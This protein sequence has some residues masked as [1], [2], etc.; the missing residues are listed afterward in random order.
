M[1]TVP[2]SLYIYANKQEIGQ[3]VV[4][5]LLDG[6]STRWSLMHGVGDSMGPSFVSGPDASSIL[7]GTERSE[8]FAPDK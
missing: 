8:A 6:M 4:A 7:S 5:F 1:Q 2:A 3:R